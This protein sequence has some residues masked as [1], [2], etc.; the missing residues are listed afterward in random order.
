MTTEIMTTQQLADKLVEYCRTNQHDRVYK[1]LCG[2][3]MTAYEMEGVPNGVTKGIENLLAKSAGWAEDVQEM[4]EM[5][6]F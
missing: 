2:P 1:E 4:H 3:E 5:P 6:G